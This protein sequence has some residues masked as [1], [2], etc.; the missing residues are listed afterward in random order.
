MEHLSNILRALFVK[1]SGDAVLYYAGWLM[2]EQ[3]KISSAMYLDT[4]IQESQIMHLVRKAN[5]YNTLDQD[6]I[7][8]QVLL[9]Q[10]MEPDC[11]CAELR[12][13]DVSIFNVLLHFGCKTIYLKNNE[14]ICHYSK[15]LR[16]HLLTSLLGEDIITT[17]YLASS[18]IINKCERKNFNWQAFIGHNNKELNA[19]LNRPM[20]DLHMHLKGSSLNFDLSWLSVMNNIDRM[21]DKFNDVYDKRKDADWD[22]LLYDKLYRASLIRLYLASKTKLIGLNMSFAE[23]LNCLNLMDGADIKTKKAYYKDIGFSECGEFSPCFRSFLDSI[24]KFDYNDD[25]VSPYQ[26]VDYIPIIHYDQESIN[27]ILSSERELMYNTFRLILEG[28]KDSK[29]LGTLFY[30]YLSYKIAFRHAIVQLNSTVGFHNF[31]E[32]EEL[33]DNFI[34]DSYKPFL[35][36]AAIESFLKENKNRY[37][38]TRIVPGESAED[39]LKKIE[40]ISGG[41]DEKFR[42]Q[43]SIILHFIKKRD[44][45]DDIKY[46]HKLFREDIK[47]RAFAIYHFRNNKDNWDNNSLAGCVVGIDAANS[48]VYCRPEVFAQAFRF[49]RNHSVVNRSLNRQENLNIT[50]HVGEDF[51]DIADGLRAVEEAIIFLNLRNG[52]RLGHCLV[53][54]TDVNQYY[55]RRYHT[56]CATKQV[57]L[58]NMAWL[59]H[60][61]KRIFGYTPLCYYLESNFHRFFREVYVK[62]KN[63]N[64]TFSYENVFDGDLKSLDNIQDYYLSWLLRGNSPTF[65]IDRDVIPTSDIEKEWLNFSV[66]HHLGAELARN[67]ENAIQLHE[68][69]HNDKTVR[70][71]ADAV[72]FTIRE[73]YRED[74]YALL[75]AIQEQL[76]CKIEGKRIAI[77][78]NPSSNF[79]IGEMTRYD[80]HPIIKFFNYG[81][82]TPYLHHDIAVSIN[83]DDQ[84]VF[85]TSLEREYSLIALAME[86]NQ[87]EGYKNSPRQIIEWL[88]K[89]RQMSVEQQFSIINN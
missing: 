71:G 56:I 7:V 53:L 55:S 40:E 36:Q 5:I 10:W 23:L 8:T 37:L 83:T 87:P 75:E 47:K 67:S 17:S 54:G 44:Y 62:D 72:T 14:P 22:P 38:E 2:K 1:Q 89:I 80:E 74:F 59:H 61:C 9:S 27:S 73:E 13:V 25:N 41:V 20:A 18:D 69:Y 30:A 49:L 70:N 16:W 51:F 24:P 46:R 45:R 21:Y 15:L 11:D 32:Y 29:I 43:F 42:P 58:D 79:K 82:S 84:G 81:L 3:K 52:D 66:N 68:Y 50:F 19:V 88:D 12:F 76:L 65:G 35:Y 33:K 26:K 4:Q 77:E 86:R 6:M 39:I 28:D 31:S 60:K 48:E 85:S 63:E 64:S 34:E 78:C 57:I